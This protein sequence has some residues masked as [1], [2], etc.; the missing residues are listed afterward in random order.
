MPSIRWKASIGGP[1][2]LRLEREHPNFRLLATMTRMGE[3]PLPWAGETGKIEEA[4]L[5]RITAG[6]P[7]RVYYVAGPPALVG[8]MRGTLERAGVDSDDVRSEEFYGD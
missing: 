1:E 5:Q 7:N 2:L 6:L 4:L 8:A 3:S